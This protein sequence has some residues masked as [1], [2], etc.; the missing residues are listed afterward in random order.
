MLDIEIERYVDRVIYNTKKEMREVLLTD[1][2]EIFVKA[3]LRVK[4]QADSKE[5]FAA[6]KYEAEN[7]LRMI[8]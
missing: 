3:S 5:M 6:L 8:S 1:L 2:D 7:K 4:N